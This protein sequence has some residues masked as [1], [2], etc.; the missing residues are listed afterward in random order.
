MEHRSLDDYL[1]R[2]ICGEPLMK[3]VW[4]NWYFVCDLVPGHPG[5]CSG[6]CTRLRPGDLTE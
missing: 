2:I 6:P 3:S 4:Y 1:P 5:R